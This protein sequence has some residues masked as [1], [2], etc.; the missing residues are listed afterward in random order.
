[1]LE[2]KKKRSRLFFFNWL[3]ATNGTTSWENLFLAH[4]IWISFVLTHV[5]WFYL[6]I[7]T[8]SC[9]LVARW[10]HICLWCHCKVKI[11][12]PCCI[13]AYS[14]FSGSLFLKFFQYKMRYLVVSNC[15]KFNPL[16][17]WGWDRKIRPSW[18]PFVITLQALWCQSVIL[19]TDFSIP[20]SHSW[21]ILLFYHKVSAA[22]KPDFVAVKQQRQ[23][24][25]WAS[26]QSDQRLR[27]LLSGKYSSQTWY[28]Q[29]FNNLASL[30]SQADLFES[31][32]VGNPKDRISLAHLCTA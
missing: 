32:L 6:K 4:Q 15:R 1:M 25:V 5:R 3:S 13:S 28:W 26:V 21:W 7:K 18:S 23:K 20:P 30:C 14:G 11:T 2:R 29:N 24:P 16:F 19:R 27:C 12:S 31:S 9:M 17:V 22:S 10:P 8:N